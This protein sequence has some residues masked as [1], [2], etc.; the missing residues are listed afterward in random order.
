MLAIRADVT[1][2]PFDAQPV[3]P[4]RKGPVGT[5]PQPRYR[6]PAPS[7][8]TLATDLGQEAFTLFDEDSDVLT[9]EYK[10]NLLAPAAGAHIEAVG[11]VLKP[12]RTLTVCLLEVHGVQAGGE[13]KLVANGQ[14]TLIRVNRPAQ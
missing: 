4:N 2:H 12:G 5:W 14:Q 9:V 13:R 8:A 7:V 11:T 10:I 6:Q 1:A 3:A